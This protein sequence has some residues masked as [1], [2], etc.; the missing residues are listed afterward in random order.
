MANMKRCLPQR[1]SRK[2]GM[3]RPMPLKNPTQPPRLAREILDHDEPPP[4]NDSLSKRNYE[5]P[6]PQMTVLPPLL[7]EFK[8]RILQALIGVAL[9]ELGIGLYLIVRGL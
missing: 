4:L 8:A 5:I 6:A 7:H 1:I 3:N 9:V 2:P